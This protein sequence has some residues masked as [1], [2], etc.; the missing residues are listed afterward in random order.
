M[1]TA[2]V[3][4]TAF[5]FDMDGVIV[6]SN[7]LHRL[8]WDE[9]NRRHGVEMTEA[10]YQ[11]M[12][13]KRNGEIIRGYLGE[14]LTDAE[15]SAHSA[16]KERLYRELMAPRVEDALVGGV[17]EFIRRHRVLPMAVATNAELA[18][19]H[20]A[21]NGAELAEYFQV[22]V[23]GGDVANAKPHP[24]IYL[25]A[26]ELLGMSPDRCIVF[27]DSY[28]GVQ[29]GL[30]AGMRVVGVATTHDDLPGVSLLIRDFRDPM[31]EEWLS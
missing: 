3:T 14:H 23:T 15:V 17:R 11:A 25:R 9:Y 16:A 29:A 8:A 18:N 30:A 21:L 10:M 28:V 4:D 1:E 19:V 5:L 2:P 22:I 31:L 13:G 26:A 24:E 20:M 27:E 7:P 12:Y 6:D